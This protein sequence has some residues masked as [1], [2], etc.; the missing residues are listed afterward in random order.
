M[1]STLRTDDAD[2][3]SRELVFMSDRT[4]RLLHLARDAFLKH[5]LSALPAAERLGAEIHRQEKALIETCT[6]EGRTLRE[7]S[8]QDAVFVPMHLERIADNLE[9]LLALTRRMITEGV[10]F[11]DRARREIG[12]LYEMAA[13]LLV[14]VRDALRTNNRTLI[15]QVRHLGQ[16]CEIMANEFALFHEQ[17]LIEGVCLPKA[18]SI[19]LAMLD[20]LK[21]IE[22][23]ARQ[24]VE[25]LAPA[26]VGG[27]RPAASVPAAAQRTH[28]AHR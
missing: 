27:S 12:T 4:I 16:Q 18:S 22:W 17:R 20:H 19:Y 24:I 10:L 23:H 2:A 6:Q 14:N 7:R 1:T 5:D 21:G 26:P 11:T 9:Q 3:Q 25:K 8:G 28:T 15:E 13:E